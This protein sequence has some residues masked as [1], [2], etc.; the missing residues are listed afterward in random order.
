M[1]VIRISLSGPRP[2]APIVCRTRDGRPYY[3]FVHGEQGRGRW[4]VRIPLGARDFPVDE[5]RRT[6]EFMEADFRLVKLGKKDARGNELFLLGRG[7]S[8]GAYLVLWSL[9]PGYRGS[10]GYNLEGQAEAI[11]YGCEEQVAAGRLGGADCPVV[12]VTGPCRLTWHRRG[13][14]Y[15]GQPDWVAEFDGES[16]RVAPEAECALEEAAF[17]Y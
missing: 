4:E 11:A 9:S 14:L 7:E 16:W 13:R 10:A 8:D 1:R 12:L 3:A 15:G 5:E 6:E 17:E 2:A